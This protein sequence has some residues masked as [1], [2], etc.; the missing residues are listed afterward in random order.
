[1]KKIQRNVKGNSRMIVKIYSGNNPLKDINLVHI[2]IPI[3]S[4]P[5]KG[6]TY[7]Y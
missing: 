6:K 4:Y 5:E 7:R 1:V 2:L 3:Y